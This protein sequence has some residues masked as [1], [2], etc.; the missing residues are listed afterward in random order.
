MAVIRCVTTD[1]SLHDY[2]SFL[3][4]DL[5]GEGPTDKQELR[6]FLVPSERKAS[7][8]FGMTGVSSPVPRFAFATD[9]FDDLLKYSFR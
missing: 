4:M 9:L 2:R 5:F 7:V 3:Q 6:T 1:L 8:S